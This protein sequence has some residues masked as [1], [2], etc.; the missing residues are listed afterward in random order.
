MNRQLV[1]TLSLLS[2][3]ALFAQFSTTAQ[4]QASAPAS[5]ASRYFSDSQGLAIADL[6]QSV[7]SGNK[8]LQ[9]AREQLRQA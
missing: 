2:G 4:D 7:L 6:V 1:V 9:A 3:S 8:D 5:A